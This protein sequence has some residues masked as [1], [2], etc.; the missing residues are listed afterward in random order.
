MRADAAGP[1]LFRPLVGRG[2]A[3]ADLDGDGKLDVI[4]TAN[5]GAA[6]VL[7]NEG[8]T[9]HHWLRLKLVGDGKR[10]NTSAIGAR[11]TLEAGGAVQQREVC[12]SRGYMSQSELV[13]TFGLGEATRVDRV[14]VRWPGRD[15]GPPQVVPGLGVDR[16]HRIV[17]GAAR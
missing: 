4:L 10:S 12:S 2:C 5:G 7:R 8:G 14:T 16:E 11:V 3:Y 1:D 17:Q 13:L 15:A 6:R 9:G